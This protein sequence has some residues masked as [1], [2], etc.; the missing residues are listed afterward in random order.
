MWKHLWSRTTL[1]ATVASAVAI[2]GLVASHWAAYTA[3]REAQRRDLTGPTSSMVAAGY[4]SNLSTAVKALRAANKDPKA[5]DPIDLRFFRHVARSSA[6]SLETEIIPWI[7]RDEEA[8]RR[9]EPDRTVEDEERRV[10][11]A[12]ELVREAVA[13]DAALVGRVPGD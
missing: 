6:E 1:L 13:L 9:R 5:F 8:E 12:R 10:R 2:G 4:V 11:R 3:G 7:R